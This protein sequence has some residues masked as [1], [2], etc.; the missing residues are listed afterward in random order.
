MQIY[1]NMESMKIFFPLILQYSMQLKKNKG[2]DKYMLGTIEMDSKIL[3]IMRSKTAYNNKIYYRNVSIRV[4]TQSV[5]LWE[6]REE[7]KTHVRKKFLQKGI[8]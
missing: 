1:T 2:I 4:N 7:E 6:S 8:Y 5:Y 3:K